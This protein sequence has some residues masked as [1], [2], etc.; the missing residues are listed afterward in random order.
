MIQ[1]ELSLD[2]LDKWY[3]TGYNCKKLQEWSQA[4][5]LK[6]VDKDIKYIFYSTN[7][8]NRSQIITEL[9]ILILRV[10][11]SYCIKFT[12][13]IVVMTWYYMIYFIF[14][15]YLFFFNI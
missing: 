13:E 3:F 5:P 1:C 6:Y 4:N 8:I 11:L 2:F 15:L 12:I 10:L 14:I 9:K 7:K